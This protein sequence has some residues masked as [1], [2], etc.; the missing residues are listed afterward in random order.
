MFKVWSRLYDWVITWAARFYPGW[1]RWIFFGLISSFLYLA[2]S[3]TVFA[4]FVRRGLFGLPLLLHVVV[5]G[6]FAVCLTL[7]VIWRARD[8]TGDVEKEFL[9]KVLFWIFVVSG[10]CLT[11]TS[12]SSMVSF[13]TMPVQIRMIG[14][15][16]FCGFLSLFAASLFVY[17]AIDQDREE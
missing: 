17:Y 15:H 5:G 7:V 8:Y 9:L 13:L 10:L 4:L 16:R 11:L 6:V 3:G 14:W 12:L 1:R 2:L